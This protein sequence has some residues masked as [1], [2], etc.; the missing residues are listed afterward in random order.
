MD[1]L[2]K[3]FLG[4]NASQEEPSAEGGAGEALSLLSQ[5][6][7]Q[8]QSQLEKLLRICDTGI[9]EYEK[10]EGIVRDE[11]VIPS[12]KAI[13][14]AITDTIR[15][16]GC[17]VQCWTSRLQEL[18]D[19]ESF[20][21]PNLRAQQRQSPAQ[22]LLSEDMHETSDGIVVGQINQDGK[23]ERLGKKNEVTGTYFK[24]DSGRW[25]K[26]YGNEPALEQ[27]APAAVTGQT[28]ARDKAVKWMEKAGRIADAALR[29][30]MEGRTAIEAIDASG[31]DYTTRLDKKIETLNRASSRHSVA[32]NQLVDIL[33]D[34]AVLPAQ[35]HD[36]KAAVQEH[37]M[38]LK[39]DRRG[40]ESLLQQVKNEQHIH[41]RKMRDPTEANFR[42]LWNEGQVESIK[43]DFAR[44]QNRAEGKEKDWLERY[45]VFIKP[46]P[47][48]E[49]YEPWIVHAHFD[50]SASDAEPICVHMKRDAEKDWGVDQKPYHS[51]PLNQKTF[52]LVKEN[53]QKQQ[54]APKKGA[55]RRR[56]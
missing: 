37:L 28:A 15:T 18:E 55:G 26:D 32:I 54:A 48:G 11:R 45:T 23:L 1:R 21:P 10:L 50:S 13:A 14:E 3:K 7:S 16:H 41:A 9:K 24:D 30:S 44:R 12:L 47:Q 8:S 5:L 25:I 4:N 20:L 43:K 42:F 6:D 36:P 39:E 53:V 19:K 17:I 29:S 35:D 22:L 27:L 34:L 49:Q 40:V 52:D 31:D 38:R 33:G 2:V 46:G 51:L 56:R